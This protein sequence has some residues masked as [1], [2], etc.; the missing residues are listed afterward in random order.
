MNTQQN[1][2]ERI[3]D[4]I[5]GLCSAEEK[6]F[7]EELI[8]TNLEWRKTYGELLEVHKAMDAALEPDQPSM[9]F[10][11]NVMEEIARLRITPAASSYINKKV[12]WGIALF[13]LITMA[14]L[15][16]YGFAQVNWHSTGDS[17]WLAVDMRKIE[18]N[19]IFNNNYTN[20]FM[21]MNVVLGLMLLDMQLGR[22]KKKLQGEHHP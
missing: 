12:I 9:R 7:V 16:A 5:D 22:K 19:K 3:W 13:F 21:M 6:T 15:L 14:G 11:Q 1:M 8:N 18:W 2:E 10:T 4:Y 20:V 17:S